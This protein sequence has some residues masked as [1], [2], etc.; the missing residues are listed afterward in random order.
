MP[1][2]QLLTDAAAHILKGKASPLFLHG[3]VEHHLHQH[4][5]QLLP[6]QNGLVCINGFQRLAGLFQKI[7]ADGRMGL[8]LIPRAAIFR[9]PQDAD[10]L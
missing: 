2:H 1:E 9:V 6:E 8:H 5:P 7:F 3:S 4:V 10:H